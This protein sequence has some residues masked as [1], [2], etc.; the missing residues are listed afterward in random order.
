MAVHAVTGSFSGAGTLTL[1]GT[2]PKGKVISGAFT[3]AGTLAFD[4]AATVYSRAITNDFNGTVDLAVNELYL[5]IE[6]SQVWYDANWL[7][8][9]VLYLQAN[10]E[11]IEV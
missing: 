6:R 5:L 2:L 9:R 1:T 11:G 4:G 10:N 3:G 7:Y 8:R